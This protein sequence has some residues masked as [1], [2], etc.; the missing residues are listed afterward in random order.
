[1]PTLAPH[2]ELYTFCKLASLCVG[3][4]AKDRHYDTLI[5]IGHKSSVE[6]MT[7]IIPT[8]PRE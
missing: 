4:F 6:S 1:M 2:I 5:A 3:D 8:S 7:E